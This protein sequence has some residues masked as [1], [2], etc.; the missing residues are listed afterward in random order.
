MFTRKLQFDASE[1]LMRVKSSKWGA[2]VSG[3][4]VLVVLVQ[5]ARV[6]GVLGAAGCWDL[7]LEF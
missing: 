1:W 4:W 3:C 6:L 5:G 2:A 7:G